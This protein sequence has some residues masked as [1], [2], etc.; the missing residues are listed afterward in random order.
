MNECSLTALILDLVENCFVENDVSVE[1][2]PQ[3]VAANL[4]ASV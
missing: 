2:E 3:R 4:G 1:N